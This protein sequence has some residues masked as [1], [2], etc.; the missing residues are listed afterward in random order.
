[1][2]QAQSGNKGPFRLLGAKSKGSHRTALRL[3]P[4]W[5]AEVSG[6]FWNSAPP[7]TA[8]GTALCFAEGGNHGAL[9]S[10]GTARGAP[11]RG[12]SHPGCRLSARTGRAG[13]GLPR[14]PVRVVPHF[15]SDHRDPGTPGPPKQLPRPPGGGASTS[16]TGL[17]LAARASPTT[18]A[19]PD[20]LAARA[21]PWGIVGRRAAA[22]T[23]PC[24]AP[25]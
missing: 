18:G 4:R 24:R 5:R 11:L 3:R 10:G 14:C 16:G 21:E 23:S 15:T 6:S 13:P 8:L 9:P 25:R 2:A 22:A 17:P 1:M 12:V 19:A 7:L 20:W